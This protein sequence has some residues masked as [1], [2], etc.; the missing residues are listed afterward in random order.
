M[1]RGSYGVMTHYLIEPKGK[2][3]AERTAD[4]NRIADQFDI[5]HFMRQFQETGR[6]LADFHDRSMHGLSVQP[7]IHISTHARPVGR[8]TGTLRWKS[9]NA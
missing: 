4:L 1:A 3:P 9:P 6:R 8:R 7:R 2:T 5:D